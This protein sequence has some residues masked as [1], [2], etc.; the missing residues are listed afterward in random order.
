M[1]AGAPLPGPLRLSPTFAFA[2]R[3]VKYVPESVLA[4]FTTGVGLKLL[5]GQI[6]ELHDLLDDPGELN[7]LI[8]RV[9][10]LRAFS[11]GTAD[12]RPP[13]PNLHVAG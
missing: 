5:D 3:V 4:G 7:R 12:H 6:P 2:G 11:H 13:A 8:R 1:I 9:E 10:S